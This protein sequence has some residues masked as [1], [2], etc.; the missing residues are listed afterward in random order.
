MPYRNF[1]VIPIFLILPL[2]FGLPTISVN[3]SDPTHKAFTVRVIEHDPLLLQ[4]K[5]SGLEVYYR[6]DMKLC[7]RR[8]AWFDECKA[9]RREIHSLQWDPI[10]ESFRVE[11]DRHG[12][13]E[14]PVISNISSFEE[15]VDEISAVRSI[16]LDF[17]TEDD[18]SF[19]GENNLYLRTKVS[20]TCR[21]QSSQTLDR[22]SSILTLGLVSIGSSNSGWIDFNI[23]K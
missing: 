9:G 2:L 20:F 3:W 1:L 13:V 4:C 17:L 19:G 16:P 18:L 10:S 8:T 15:A 22:L 6:F 5:T 23:E 14:G 7:R 11:S 12:D 21:G